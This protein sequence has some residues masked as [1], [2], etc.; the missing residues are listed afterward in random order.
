MDNKFVTT[1]NRPFIDQLQKLLDSKYNLLVHE[2][3]KPNNHINFANSFINLIDFMNELI[4][5]LGKNKIF[6][7][8]KHFFFV[9]I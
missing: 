1:I 2:S 5:K 3:V 6:K 8:W 7:V 4:K 9:C